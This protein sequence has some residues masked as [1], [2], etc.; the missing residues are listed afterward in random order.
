MR[1][2]H[3]HSNTREYLGESDA[4]IDPLETELQGKN[5]YLCPA[6][7]TFTK[8][9]IE[10]LT[11]ERLCFE[12]GRWMA[13]LIPVEVPPEA[14][15]EIQP[16]PKRVEMLEAFNAATTIAGLKKA[17]KPLLGIPEETSTS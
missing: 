12:D 16:D 17:L 11:G 9:D 14:P 6:H 10:V 13:R 5:I 4:R 7:A 1:I 3:Y 2:Y 8:P 15:E